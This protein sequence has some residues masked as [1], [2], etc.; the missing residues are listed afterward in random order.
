MFI[1]Q[2]PQ[3]YVIIIVAFHLGVFQDI[4]IYAFPKKG[5]VYASS[6]GINMII[7]LHDGP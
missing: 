5:K 3:A 1:E 2:N 6:L 4:V 7:N